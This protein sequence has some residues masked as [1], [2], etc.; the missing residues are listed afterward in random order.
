MQEENDND[1]PFLLQEQ[2]EQDTHQVSKT[3]TLVPNFMNIQQNK[4]LQATAW[5]INSIVSSFYFHRPTTL[6]THHCDFI[7]PHLHH[8]LSNS[9]TPFMVLHLISVA[10]TTQQKLVIY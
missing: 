4:A 7:C 2:E 10:Y 5:Q 1:P 6:Q 8:T 9:V 3:I